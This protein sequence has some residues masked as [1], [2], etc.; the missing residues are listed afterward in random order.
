[1]AL[2]RGQRQIQNTQN[3]MGIIPVADTN[4]INSLVEQLG[5][6]IEK[7]IINTANIQDETYRSNFNI[8]SMKF[9]GDLAIK[10]AS[11]PDG[12][13]K[14]SETYIN[15]A[16]GSTPKHL[17]QYVRQSAESTSYPLGFKIQQNFITKQ[18]TDMN[19]TLQ[20]ELGQFSNTINM[21]I[22]SAED[23]A[24][25]TNSINQMIN[26]WN[27]SERKLKTL[28]EPLSLS[29]QDIDAR[30]RSIYISSE[31]TRAMK[32]GKELIKQGKLTEALEY[33]NEWE[34][35]ADSENMYY[36]SFT[37]GETKDSSRI[38]RNELV[39]D[40]AN[41]KSVIAG[42]NKI[43]TQ[44]IQ[45]QE[46]NTKK[47]L[48]NFQTPFLFNFEDIENLDF[49]KL[50]GNPSAKQY[51]IE[52]LYNKKKNIIDGALDVTS[53]TNNIRDY[54]VENQKHIQEAIM[55]Q[56]TNSEL[57]NGVEYNGSVFDSLMS[58]NQ[59]A[60][61]TLM[62]ADTNNPNT[63][64]STDDERLIV[65]QAALAHTVL[66]TQFDIG[67]IDSVTEN[68][69][70]NSLDSKNVDQMRNG[71]AIFE[72]LT[73]NN[74]MLN[75]ELGPYREMY[76]KLAKYPLMEQANEEDLQKWINGGSEEYANH[77][78]ILSTQFKNVDLTKQSISHLNNTNVIDNAIAKAD[79]TGGW[80]LE[81]MKLL[82]GNNA[83]DPSDINTTELLKDKSTWIPFLS[84][85]YN[86]IDEE[87]S[88]AIIENAKVK[89]PLLATTKG[90]D[91]EAWNTALENSMQDVL[92][93]G[94]GMTSFNGN[95]F[96]NN[97][98]LKSDGF[99]QPL[100]DLPFVDL[101]GPNSI[102]TP[103]VSFAKYPI[104]KMYNIPP[105]QIQIQIRNDY[106]NMWDQVEAESGAEGLAREFN[107]FSDTGNP[108]SKNEFMG[109]IDVGLKNGMVMLKYI[110][111][112][113]NVTT[114]DGQMLPAYTVTIRT[115]SEDKLFGKGV[116]GKDIELVDFNNLQNNWRPVDQTS[117]GSGNLNSEVLD[118]NN[119]VINF[120]NIKTQASYN[121]IKRAQEIDPTNITQYKLMEKLI[122]WAAR[123][124]LS[125][126]N[127]IGS[128]EF[129]SLT[130]TPDTFTLDDIYDSFG[131]RFPFF[132]NKT[133]QE[134]Y[135][136]ELQKLDKK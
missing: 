67:M 61:T 102:G 123:T 112:T 10:F 100:F 46:T 86:G 31:T 135:Q 32:V 55:S 53:G 23:E 26:L 82:L 35:G 49:V 76:Q 91:Q 77:E 1:M 20:I 66:N 69:L 126:N 24:Q 36:K 104:E 96:T 4:A 52:K 105:E 33:I 18:K 106:S 11:D 6:T 131:D 87:A 50:A 54:S 127:A 59:D 129:E 62:Y 114:Q 116:I 8:E 45:E 110:E 57:F 107:V 29:D 16:V 7:S 75:N 5:P 68:Y 51:E 130:G 30:M 64:Q 3:S 85:M 37:A 41:Y 74:V 65:K 17:Q 25:E 101:F 28:A 42:N 73:N 81:G 13:K 84:A 44:Q 38:I 94:Y 43:I 56:I 122:G 93:Q 132:Q 133:F 9:F 125:L 21:G 27:E 136:E 72:L 40:I 47:N 39:Q 88:L 63:M 14:A 48:D 2:K 71:L 121:A 117:I 115:Q 134:L 119:K 34:R 124:E 89:Y 90:F 120:S 99:F 128:M 60:M 92:D 83:V 103:N 118:E 109:M 98:E 95:G 97:E 113:N 80:L 15:K 70:R 111:G 108:L 12:Y 19:D 79:L 22:L 78:S 58:G